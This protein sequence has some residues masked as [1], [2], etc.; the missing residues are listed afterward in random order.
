MCAMAQYV[1]GWTSLSWLSARLLDTG[2]VATG[3]GVLGG[4]D[5]R[6]ATDSVARFESIVT[7]AWKV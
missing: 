4:C 2:V 5:S 7:N 6:I 1:S 3:D